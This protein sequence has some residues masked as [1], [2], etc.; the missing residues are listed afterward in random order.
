MIRNI[1][2]VCL[3]AICFLTMTAEEPVLPP[4]GLPEEEWIMSYDKYQSMLYPDSTELRN[5]KRNVTVCKSGSDIYI[6]G[7][8]SAF[9]DSW[10]KCS[11]IDNNTVYIESIQLISHL[12]GFPVYAKSGSMYTRTKA[13]YIQDSCN[14]ACLYYPLF[15][16]SV[17]NIQTEY[18]YF[19]SL[20][21]DGK[22]IVCI[23][24]NPNA[25]EC[26]ALFYGMNVGFTDL[27]QYSQAGRVNEGQFPNIDFPVKF[28][29][30]KSDSG[31]I[32]SIDSDTGTDSGKIYILQ[33][34]IVDSKSI[35]PGVYIRNGKKII[36]K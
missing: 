25:G 31:N 14:A 20:S 6:K 17:P 24:D 3:L 21:E 8:F 12:N 15:P 27:V 2:V 36:I 26:N 7:V 22:H 32:T 4:A 1:T 10:I 35:I 19:Y 33:G 16:N 5:L 9:P 23:D 29:F 28:R 30:D 34:N 11:V 18:K 13:D